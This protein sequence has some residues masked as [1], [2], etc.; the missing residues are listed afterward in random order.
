MNTKSYYISI[1]RDNGFVCFPIPRYADDYENQK[2]ADY[3][4][5]TDGQ[6]QD[7]PILDSENYGIKPGNNNG[8]CI[9]DL[10]HKELYRQFAEEQIKN[11]FMVIETP[12]GWHIPVKGLTGNIQKVM[13]YNKLIEP[14]KQI[15]EIQSNLQYVMGVGSDV[16]NKDK[17][18]RM[19]YE[20]KGS[21]I[22]WDGKG[23]D[24]N[25]LVDFICKKL[26]VKAKPTE[27]SANYEQRKR[28][29]DGKPPTKGTS[30]QYW[31]NAAIQCLTDGN[32]LEEA[33][34]RI[35]TVYENWPEQTRAWSNIEA[36]LKDAYENGEPLKEGRHKSD[37]EADA[38]KLCQNMITD[39]KLYSDQE[40][41]EIFENKNGFLENITSQLHKEIQIIYPELTSN[42]LNDIIFRL[43]GLAPDLPPTN[44]DLIVF[45]N[46]V[47]DV[48]TRK[49][50]ITDE[51]ADIGFKGYKY[52]L[53]TDENK[54]I[55]FIKCAYGNVPETEHPRLNQAFKACLESRLDSRITVIYGKSRV[56]K[57]T[58]LTIMYKVMTKNEKYALTLELS[59]LLTD[60]FI[61][62]G[63]KGKRLLI[64]TDM[65]E[66]YK[67]FAAIKALTGEEEKLERGFHQTFGIFENK[68]KIIGTANY[69]AKIPENEKNAMYSDRLSLVH[70]TRDL[71]YPSN[72]RYASDV[73]EKE[74]EK[75]ISW[76]LNIPYEACSYEDGSTVRKEWESLASPELEYMEKN[77]QFG[78]AS[79]TTP[80]MRL[81]NDYQEKYQTAIPVKQFIKSLE[82][83]G[84]YIFKNQV[85]DIVPIYKKAEVRENQSL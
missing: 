38:V 47:F 8:T 46:G 35:K 33:T 34:I 2:A 64:L 71:P 5:K 73:A 85:H 82:D 48:V 57:S 42:V 23:G 27:R 7:Q 72:N 74:G 75:I 62:A 80:I 4:Y 84:F 13:L 14:T 19:F 53:P 45:D 60:P 43:I 36:K 3:R 41:N 76:I 54:P 12:N 37:K 65:P 81:R 22:I 1:Y 51:I 67:D 29:K 15:V 17:K 30:N 20:N 9:I 56:G 26:E 50:I 18:C 78:S 58:A 59:Q 25:N 66:T 52:L 39:R 31:Y 16:F 77:W 68:I 32:T 28:F 61:K 6:T 83:Q 79:D 69:L 44:K 49:L 63:I 40:T 11:G 21:D 70:N 24:F 55:E 10:D